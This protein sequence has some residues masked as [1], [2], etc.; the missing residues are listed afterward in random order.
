MIFMPMNTA[1]MN[2]STLVPSDTV[3]NSAVRVDEDD[4]SLSDWLS[5]QETLN[6][7]SQENAEK[8]WEAQKLADKI[9]ME[10]SA[11]EVS[12]L[13]SWQEQMSNSAYQRAVADLRQAGL[14]PVLALGSAASTPSGSVAS[15]VSSARNAAVLNLE[16][17]TASYQKLLRQLETSENNAKTAANASKY[18]ANLRAFSDIASNF[19]GSLGD[20]LGSKKGKFGF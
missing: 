12:K 6:R 2:P 7:F 1:V 8:A 18:A 14:N 20:I 17:Y 19:I 3:V 4:S 11:S 5:A 13:R 9:A 16:N 10:F 15:G